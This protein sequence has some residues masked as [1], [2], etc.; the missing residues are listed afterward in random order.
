MG[1]TMVPLGS[2]AGWIFA[3]VGLLVVTVCFA[4]LMA[5]SAVSSDEAKRFSWVF[6]IAEVLLVTGV[7]LI[8]KYWIGGA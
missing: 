3:V 6:A 5:E 8:V 2:V 1:A 4:T 7:I